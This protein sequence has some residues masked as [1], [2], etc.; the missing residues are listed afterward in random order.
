M[1]IHNLEGALTAQRLGFNRAVLSREL[2]IEE[3][4]HIC[5]NTNIEI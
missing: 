5:K 4:S 2:S 1:T 3:I